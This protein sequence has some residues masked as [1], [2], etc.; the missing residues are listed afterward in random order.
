MQP[1]TEPLSTHSPPA[2][3]PEPMNRTTK[4]GTEPTLYF[5][6]YE[7]FGISPSRD[8]PAQ[9]AGVRTDLDFNIIGEPLVIYCKPPAD[10]LPEPEACLITGITPQKAMKDGLCEADFIRQ[11]HE[12]F[13]APGTCVLGYNS[14]R[15]DDE[16][17]RNTLYRNFYDPYAYSWQNGNSRWDILDMVRACY[18]L[19]PEGITW[20]FDDEGKPSFKLENLTH[21]N[22]I[23][24]EQAH[25]ALSDVLA[26]I[27]M[28]RLIKEAQPRLFDYLFDLRSKHKVKALIDVVSMKPLVHVSGMFSP[29][30]GCASWVS[31]L[32]WH[33]TNQNAV[34]VVDLTRDPQVLLDLDAHTLRERLYT[35][36][37]D[38]GELESVPLKLVH[39]NKCP[40]LAPAATL[41]PERADELGID[42]EQCRKSLDLLRKHPEIRE[43]VVEV[44]NQEWQGEQSRD[45]DLMLYSSFFG[46]GD[47]AAMEMVRATAPDLLGERSFSFSDARLPEM[48]FRYRARNWPHTLSEEE[49]RRWRSHCADY[50][51]AR[52]PEYAS[53]LDALASQYQDDESRFKVLHQ[54]YRYL[55]DL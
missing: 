21:V 30:Q 20:C 24:H 28:A 26:T 25:D 27:A 42:R 53:R 44:F 14:I 41:T 29:W 17:T 46:P 45:P 19:R 13:A 18:A 39:I 47:K 32:A 12:E 38:L 2:D 54:I 50:F 9:F 49:A 6:D 10:Y 37:D 15:F 1:M 51:G 22:G 43:K 52:L 35:R 5:H 3:E 34:I 36:R 8:R 48:L 31:P 16:V 7:T 4:P 11:I 40:V 23:G 33:P 55:E